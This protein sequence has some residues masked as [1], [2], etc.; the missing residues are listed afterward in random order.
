M[1]I[2]ILICGLRRCVD[3][4][5]NEIE[6]L[7]INNIDNNINI[8]FI[9]CLNNN[10][11]E[12]NNLVY[13]E[14]FSKKNIIKNLFINDIHNN[15]Y[16][17]SLNYSYKVFNGLKILPNNYDLY[18]IVRT[19]LILQNINLEQILNLDNDKLYFAKKN[20]NQFTKNI[21]NRI[22]D[23]IIITKNYNLLLELINLYDFNKNI[24]NTNYLDI[25]LYNYLNLNNIKYELIDIN[26]KLILSKCNVIAIAGDS[27]SGKTTLLKALTP[28]FEK[29]NILQLETDRYHKWERG[30]TNYQQYT[31]LNPYANH[32]EKMYEDVYDLKIGNEIYQVDYNHHNGKFTQKE[33]IESK[34]NIVIC[35]LHTIYG[36]K[37]K[38]LLDIKIYIDTDRELLKKWKI[39]R[40]VYER[41]YT[42]EKV[43]K[44]IEAREKDYEEY[45][46]TQKEN[47]DIIINFY[48]LNEVIECNFIIQNKIIINNLLEELLKLNYELKYFDNN[49]IVKLN[50]QIKID[51]SYNI[52]NIFLENDKIFKSNYYKEILYFLYINFNYYL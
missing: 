14:V 26:Y 20:I 19:D 40:D 44:Q 18:M 10:I 38:D 1:K 46:I 13:N 47:A 42:M 24:N 7:F 48:E 23:N 41:G 15:S 11:D 3:L 49:L 16:I 25:V 27:G 50:N 35:G 17:N 33:K 9:T 36:N 45:I 28:L 2:C 29:E 4:V 30:D 51:C 6:T 12:K 43:L 32:L 37:I 34:K 39:Q 8:D 52:N 5:I 21:L 22:N 31:H